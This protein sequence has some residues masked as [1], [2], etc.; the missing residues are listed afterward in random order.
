[1]KVKCTCS[2]NTAVGL[3]NRTVFE[4]VY[5]FCN[6]GQENLRNFRWE[7]FSVRT[8][9][10][11]KRYVRIFTQRDEKNHRGDDSTDNQTN[12]TR[13][14]E[15]PG[16]ILPPYFDKYYVFEY[17]TNFL[18]HLIMFVL[19]FFKDILVVQWISIHCQSES[20]QS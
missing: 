8:D 5:Y 7:D 9:P 11:G 14:Y 17:I 20:K 10:E 13:M 4:M 18:A 1:M 3:F 12:Q 15:M 16:R 2:L 19:F 6:K